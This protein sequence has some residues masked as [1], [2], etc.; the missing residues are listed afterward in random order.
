MSRRYLFFVHQP[1]SLAILR[2]LQAAI[3]ARGGESAWFFHGAGADHLLPDERYLDSIEAIKAFR[4]D[5]VFV[6]GNWVPD[7][8]PGLKVQV[9]HGLETKN[10]K[11][12]FRIRGLF[13]LYCTHGPFT[14]ERFQALAERHKH[15]FVAETGWPKIDP[16]FAPEDAAQPSY[17]RSNRP[18]ILYASTFTRSLTS[19]PWL[20]DQIAAL[21]ES[22]D[23]DW[24]VTLHPKMDP[25]VV[26]R[27]KALEGPHLRYVET[28]D[29]LPLL[30][31]ADVMVSDT[32]SIVF[33]FLMLDKPVVTLRNMKPGPHLI[34]IQTP[35][36]LPTAL[37]RALQP[38]EARLRAIRA[39]CNY[40]H[41]YRDGR[42]SERIL[43][44]VDRSLSTQASLR[45]K[46]PNVWRRLQMRARFRYYRLR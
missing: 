37:A 5:A 3:R 14:T 28:D 19:A 25:E 15:F 17:R 39:F 9:F 8:I 26:A 21:A 24:L 7:F 20:A 46:P 2:P 43:D 29:V 38:E 41:P 11:D 1:Y 27:Y 22:G 44:A 40:V 23:L 18:R 42:S 32:S 30:K 35:S 34:D 36:E 31:V 4:P 13:D 6:P 10:P 16:L 45:H 12:H 33:E